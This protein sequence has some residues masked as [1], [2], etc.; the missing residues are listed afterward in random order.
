MG[1]AHFV[2]GWA[3][4]AKAGNHGFH[5][6]LTAAKAVV[7]SK[8]FRD[9]TAAARSHAGHT[10]RQLGDLVG[11]DGGDNAG[12]DVLDMVRHLTERQTSSTS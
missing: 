8:E 3:L 10:L 1:L 4:G 6:V 7:D 5:E 2:V 12:A 11:T 9:L